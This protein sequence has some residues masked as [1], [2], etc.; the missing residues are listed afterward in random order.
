MIQ[1]E[2]TSP[3]SEKICVEPGFPFEMSFDA[4]HILFISFFSVQGRNF[5]SIPSRVSRIFSFSFSADK[6][7]KRNMRRPHYVALC[8]SA[9]NFSNQGGKIFPLFFRD[10]NAVDYHLGSQLPWFFL[11]WK[12]SKARSWVIVLNDK[13]IKI[14]KEMH[15][16]FFRWV[17]W[18]KKLDRAALFV[19]CFEFWQVHCLF[20]IQ[21]FVPVH[22]RGFRARLG[23]TEWN[24]PTTSLC[25]NDLVD[26]DQMKNRNS[27]LNMKRFTDLSSREPH[28]WRSHI[29]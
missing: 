28:G 22:L 9:K 12:S 2:R 17:S 8:D 29:V 21:R 15:R 14:K 6:L 1:K 10:L 11:H 18:L 24:I 20:Q 25:P 26:F 16:K 13:E 7:Q 27:N 3:S 23:Q 5:Q 19:L 4:R